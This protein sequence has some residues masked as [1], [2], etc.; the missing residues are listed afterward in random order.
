SA[1]AVLDRLAG[2]LPGRP[3]TS[4]HRNGVGLLPLRYP[5][6]VSKRNKF[7][8][9]W[10]CRDAQR[11][12][13]KL[14]R[15]ARCALCRPLGAF[16]QGSFQ[17]PGV[18]FAKLPAKSARAL[19]HQWAAPVPKRLG[20]STLTPGPIVEEIA[21]RLL[22][23]TFAPAGLG[24]C[25]ASAKALMFSTSLSSENEA[26]PTPAWTMP[27]F[28]T[29]NSTDPPLAPFTAFVTSI[30][31]VPTF[32]FG[33]IP[34]GPST[35]PRRPTSGIRSGVAMQRSKSISPLPTFSTRSSAPTR[36]AAEAVSPLPALPPNSPR[37][38]DVGAS[39]FGLIGLGAACEHAD[40][41]RA[42]GAV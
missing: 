26:L 6:R 16:C 41:E 17:V 23:W 9:P 30:V 19:P 29:R 42:A 14:G 28:S 25:T 13:D 22:Y 10:V 5:C 18:F 21:T 39:C 37:A 15:H 12:A 2:P 20:I 1:P 31:T 40:A 24:F 27:A 35:L 11:R 38:D 33:M 8:S 36:A 3:C 32:G 34:R 4:S 7:R